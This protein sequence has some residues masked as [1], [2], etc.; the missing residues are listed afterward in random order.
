MFFVV[1]ATHSFSQ[2]EEWLRKEK[3]IIL[4]QTKVDNSRHIWYSDY[5]ITINSDSLFY[6][7]N[8]DAILSYTLNYAKDDTIRFNSYDEFVEINKIRNNI[9][10]GIKNNSIIVYNARYNY[11]VKKVVVFKNLIQNYG[12]TYFY[13]DKKQEKVIIK[14]WELWTRCVVF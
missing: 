8:E 14:K 11:R 4:R 5:I 9:I 3:T 7:I 6:K 2:Q 13:I 1:M 12:S 10:N